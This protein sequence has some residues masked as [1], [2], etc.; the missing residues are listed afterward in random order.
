M[1]SDSQPHPSVYRVRLF[2][3][4]PVAAKSRFWYFVSYYKKVNKTAGEIISG[5]NHLK[6]NNN[7]FLIEI[8]FKKIFSQEG[9]RKD[10]RFGEELRH[11]GPIRFAIWNSQHVPWIPRHQD[12]SR[13]HSVLPGHG[14]SP[15]SSTWIHPD[16]SSKFPILICW[17]FSN[18]ILSKKKRKWIFL[19]KIT[20]FRLEKTN[21]K[22]FA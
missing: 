10:S 5:K 18:Q 14:R 8:K 20:Y 1:P 12:R 19:S 6:N 4:D 21:A 3:P 2:A 17:C 13:R 15:S 9:C 22:K 16:P 11:L 7:I